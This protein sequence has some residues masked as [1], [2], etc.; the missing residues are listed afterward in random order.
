MDDPNKHPMFAHTPPPETPGAVW[1]ELRSH[2]LGTADKA[3]DNLAPSG[4]QEWGRFAGLVHDL[5]KATPEWQAYLQ[6]A[7]A[8]PDKAHGKVD[9][10]RSGALHCHQ[11][12][13]GIPL[14]LAVAGHHG[15][16]AD[17][18]T[19][20]QDHLADPKIACLLSKALET[21]LVELPSQL[22]ALPGWISGQRE[23]NKAKRSLEFFTRMLFSALVDA[24]FL[25]TEHYYAQAG[26]RD[27]RERWTARS[28]FPP[29][30]DYLPHLENHL[31]CFR[32]LTGVQKLRAEVLETCRT[33]ARG[34]RGAWTLTVPTGGGKTL[35]GLAWALH[36][37]DAHKDVSRVILAL[38]FTTIIDQTAHVFRKVFARLAPT[39]ILEHH[40][41]LDPGHE[42]MQSRVASENW[43]APLVLT[44]QVQLF[45][46]L[47]SGRP[48][49][50]RKVHRLQNSVII[51]DEVQSLPRHLLTPI[52]DL[53]N[54]LVAHYGVSLLLMTATQPSLG[55]RMT[56]S[57][58]FPGLDPT[59][60]E[61]I[62]AEL[63][64][65]LWKGL[66]RVHTRWP[67]GWEMPA[68]DAEEY[69]TCLARRVLTH[70]QAL[71]ICHLKRDAQSLFQ[72][73]R[74]EDS[75]ALHLSAAMC[76]AH[77]RAVLRAVRQRLRLG[78]PCPL[79]STQV[80]E[81]GVDIDF[82][83]VFR[84]MAG[85]ESLAQSAGRC[86]REGRLEG[87]GQFFVFEPPTAPP[88]IL[89]EH[90]EVARTL[91]ADNPEL[92]LFAPDTF[93][94]YFSWLHD[95]ARLDGQGIQPLREE[96]RFEAVS[97]AF[98]MI[99][100][101]TTPVFLPICQ[102]ARRMLERLR[103]E[104]PSREV[105][106][107]LQPYSVS[108]YDQAF[109]ELQSNSALESIGEGFHALYQAPGPHYDAAMGFT[110]R[111]DAATLLMA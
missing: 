15:G 89:K 44:T 61:I 74:N 87:L 18:A 86:N 106:R 42:T 21:C 40:S 107:A 13:T 68:A 10:K 17:W 109:R 52:L 69:W 45:E 67:G 70:P 97:E 6:K 16:L 28:A 31:L 46:S 12:P 23:R 9:H 72:A 88:G 34:P 47:F 65:R 38:P 3:M 103:R 43:D 83:V 20:R 14:A 58:P 32:A 90:R 94:R 59:P 41:N 95:P 4:L 60:H 39:T 8:E 37:A 49:A 36:H 64:T 29:L 30:K 51:L 75:T 85:L 92:D 35:S 57:G 50:C 80:V 66:R 96:L 82:P 78:L 76:P 62:P 53:L 98:R 27:S 24:D 105:L 79:V 19:L 48:S 102:R 101:A 22:P 1:Q 2:L 93:P 77:R 91:L 71:V 55:A 63:E 26:G 81:A 54:E 73:I 11:F 5:G 56:A 84:A 99:P 100:D 25:D 108:V 104:G 7:H 33:A 111:A 110:S